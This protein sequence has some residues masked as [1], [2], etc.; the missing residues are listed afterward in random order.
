MN[1]G[2]KLLTFDVTNTLLKRKHSIGAEYLNIAAN[3]LSICRDLDTQSLIN[4]SFKIEMDSMKKEHPLYG[5]STGISCD[6]WWS[7][8]IHRTFRKSGFTEDK[9][10]KQNLDLIAKH[11]FEY[12]STAVPYQLVDNAEEV[13]KKLR[14]NYTQLKLGIISNSDYRLRSI[15]NQTGIDHLFNFVL[16][17]HQ[18]KIQKPDSAIFELALKLAEVDNGSHA[19]HIGD[20]IIKDYWAAKNSHWNALLFVPDLEKDV[21]MRADV[22][23]EDII[24]SLKDIFNHSLL[25]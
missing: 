2:L 25:H 22:K 20:E 16:I 5:H 15:L 8:L 9:L 10:S 6:Q 3:Y 7:Q 18:T 11:I 17:S 14:K 1:M 23:K 4:K 13:I 12:Y 19:V 24:Y 21:E